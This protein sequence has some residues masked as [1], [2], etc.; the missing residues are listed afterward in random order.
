MKTPLN[1]SLVFTLTGLLFSQ[2]LYAET[3]ETNDSATPHPFYLALSVG[4]LQTTPDKNTLEGKG[5]A[6]GWGFYGGYFLHPN[7]SLEGEFLWL[8]RDYERLHGSP[9]L[10]NAADNRIRV[11]ST[12]LFVNARY[13]HDFGRVRVFAG[14]GIGYDSA[15]LYISDPSSGLFT[16]EGGPD[17]SSNTV[18]QQMAGII[19]PVTL[20]GKVEIGWKRLKMEYDFGVYS[21]GENEFGGDYLYL[22]YRG[23]GF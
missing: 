16:T 1:F 3:T 8:R 7:F 2:S 15:E 13:Q 10:P 12:S 20:R 22:A 6:N 9:S 18:T 21:G 5:G 19:I 11:L 4:S 17:D 23:G 14:A